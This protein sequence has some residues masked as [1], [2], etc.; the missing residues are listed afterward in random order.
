MKNCNINNNTA[1]ANAGGVQWNGANGKLIGCTFINNSAPNGLGGA[2]S[3]G[4]ANANITNSTFKGNTAKNVAGF[5]YGSV[6]G[7]FTGCI[8]I[9]NNANSNMGALQVIGNNCNLIDSNFINNTATGHT[10]GVYWNGA[11]GIVANC[12]FIGNTAKT[13]NGGAILWMGANGS[14]TDSTFINN[15]AP[16][17]V[18]GAISWGGTSAI[19]KGSIFINNTSRAVAGAIYFASTGSIS[20]CT[21]NSE[22]IKSNGIQAMNDLNINGGKGIVDIW[23]NGTL[24]GISIVVL[25]NE[26][27][28]Y[29][30]NTNI[31]LIYLQ[32]HEH[33]TAKDNLQNNQ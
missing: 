23:I 10:G 6:N 19:I 14:L 4:G 26:T 22:W 17:S 12:N 2:V 8:F 11:N 32:N 21:F 25:N 29:P 33:E 30:P 3:W 1:G 7:T 31:N 9:D 18:G 24:S 16:N 15:S 13:I 27:Y 20:N 5:Y 28:Y